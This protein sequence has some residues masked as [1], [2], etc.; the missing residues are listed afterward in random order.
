M[1]TAQPQDRLAAATEV[2]V[3]YSAIMIAAN[4]LMQ[5]A[6]VVMGNEIT[7][8]TGVM[9]AV[10]ALVY[11]GFLIRYGTRLA[12][13][14]FGLLATHVVTYTAVNTGFFVHFFVLAAIG[15]PAVLGP[16]GFVMDPGWFG[17]VIG[18][19]GAWGL[20]LLIHAFGSI[21][22]RGFEAAH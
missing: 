3:P 6:I 5:V 11:A 15:H 16:A 19:P 1:N 12:K 13:V 4:A 2:L 18:M 10:I 20:G 9:T 17:V 8:A 22:G 21:L 14:R 7:V